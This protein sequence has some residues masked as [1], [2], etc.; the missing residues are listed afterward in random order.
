MFTV[1]PIQ[2]KVISPSTLK[3]YKSNL[4]KLAKE[5]ITTV[6]E[7]LANQEKVIQ[8]GQ[9]ATKKDP[10]KMRIFLSA[11]FY[12]LSDLPNEMKVKLYNEFQSYRPEGWQK[13]LLVSD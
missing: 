10:T 4:N 3:L 6:S 5:G 7:L 2:S 12:V 1:P 13:P 9:T 8:I 11:C